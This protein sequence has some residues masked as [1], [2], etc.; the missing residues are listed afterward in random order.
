VK[1]LLVLVA[2][3]DAEFIIKTLLFRI[4][5]VENIMPIAFDIIRHPQ[6]DP[7]VAGKAI[8]FVRPYIN[9]YRF[10]LVIFD[11]EGSGK[12]SLS[13][14]NLESEIENLLR[15]NG[16]QERSVCIVIEPE[17][18]TWLWVNEIHLHNIIDWDHETGVYAWLAE[19]NFKF[20]TN[21]TKPERPK[22][23]FE[24]ILRKQRIPRSSSLY[25]KLAQQA[26]YRQC[27]DSSFEKLITTFRNWF[28]VPE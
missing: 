3:Q 1:D 18:E 6:R 20:Y 4:P 24:T 8:D 23:A 10:L 15:Q 14:N 22:E 7:G 26:S 21:T 2:D 17:L 28:R 9:D 16:W 27:T 11:Y 5:L 19:N 25:S 12:E 13:V